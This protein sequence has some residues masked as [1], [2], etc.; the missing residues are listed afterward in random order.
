MTRR[1]HKPKP[2]T[3]AKTDKRRVTPA[4]SEDEAGA[5]AP[6]KSPDDTGESDAGTGAGLSKEPIDEDKTA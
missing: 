5:Y 1:A 4:D 6:L 2:S 3:G